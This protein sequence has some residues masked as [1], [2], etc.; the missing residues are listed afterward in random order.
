MI[1]YLWLLVWVLADIP[2]PK[3]LY[4]D[5]Q[6]DHFN[7]EEQR[8]FR[9]RVFYVDTHYKKG[10]SIFLYAGNEGAIEQF[11]YNTG[12][13]FDWASEFNALILFP[14][15]RYY[16]E[17]LPFGSTYS[18]KTENLGWLRVEQAIADY[19]TIVDWMKTKYHDE[20]AP[21]IAFG[22]SYGGVLAAAL[23]IH[24]PAS[25]DMALAASAPIPQTLNTVD[26]S[27]FFS[28]ITNVFAIHDKR[29]PG[30]VKEGF[31]EIDSQ[32]LSTLS[33]L[34]NVCG[35]LNSTADVAHLK[36][37]MTN[38][39]TMM[40]MGNYPYPANFLGNLPAW[41]MNYTCELMLAA[42]SPLLGLANVGNVVYNDSSSCND[43]Y[44][45]YVSCADQT[46]CGNGL[47]ARA[48]DYQ[49]CT[50]IIYQMTMNGV[51]DMFPPR[52]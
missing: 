38:G 46:G 50:Q 21:V 14:E 19:V 39:F 24:Y 33:S 49:E 29:C 18:F 31:A 20:D 41:P 2:E 6:L 11:Y 25:I 37:W 3:I 27:L 47:S 28:T 34:F 26:P 44:T 32:L 42:D 45:Q 23:R 36:M 52:V 7:S 1:K 51:T 15:H 22:G 13:V 17:S 12:L 16:G 9:Q 4:F 40:A 8:S 35:G 5:Q 30:L 48:W 43:I 10:G